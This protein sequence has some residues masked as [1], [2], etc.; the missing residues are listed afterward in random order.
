M[1]VFNIHRR[2]VAASVEEVGSLIDGLASPG[3]RLWPHAD[4]PA[5]RF[6]RPGITTGGVGGHGPVG[7]RVEHHE[8][9]RSV[10]LRFTGRPRGLAGR[11]QYVVQATG[12]SNCVLWHLTDITP[13]GVLRLTW[14]PFWAPLHNALIEESLDRAEAVGRTAMTTSHWSMYVRALRALGSALRFGSAGQ[15]PTTAAR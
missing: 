14:F 4:W 8:P 6:D 5:M 9:G 11:H 3:D 1:Q 15:R 10:T 2:E 7:Y 12:D 13:H